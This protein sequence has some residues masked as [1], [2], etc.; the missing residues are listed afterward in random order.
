LN[1]SHAIAYAWYSEFRAVTGRFAES[2][3][4]MRH[5]EQLDP[6]SPIMNTAL[7]SY[8]FACEYDA[9]IECLDK[10]LELD[11]HH[12]LIHFRR[13]QVMLVQ[14]R[15]GEA[16]HAMQTVVVLSD[17]SAE[18]LAGLGQAYA[19]AERSDDLQEVLTELEKQSRSRY[20]SAYSMAKILTVTDCDQAFAWLAQAYEEGSADLIEI[21]VEPVRRVTI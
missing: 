19:A 5:A 7:S 15:H 16:V 20:V 8:Y 3:A 18:T 4:V 6:L 11:P 14:G 13:G 9:A 12:F 10:A 2:I 17:R 1:P 21:A